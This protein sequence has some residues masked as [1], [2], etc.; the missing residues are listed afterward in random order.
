MESLL[1]RVSQPLQVG[2]TVDRFIENSW[3]AAV[4]VECHRRQVK[5]TCSPETSPRAADRYRVFYIVDGRCE[6]VN[7]NELRSIQAGHHRCLCCQS[8]QCS[9]FD[10]DLV[11]CYC[12]LWSSARQHHS[13]EDARLPLLAIGVVVLARVISFVRD[14]PVWVALMAQTS[15]R[16]RLAC[17]L[18][19]LLPPLPLPTSHIATDSTAA[20]QTWDS[21]DSIEHYTQPPPSTHTRPRLSNEAAKAAKAVLAG[22]LTFA[23]FGLDTHPEIHPERI[24]NN[25]VLGLEHWGLRS[26]GASNSGRGTNSGRGGNNGKGATSGRGANSTGEGANSSSGGTSSG[27]DLTPQQ[28]WNSVIDSLPPARA[29]LVLC[30]CRYYDEMELRARILREPRREQV[31]NVV[32]R[33]VL[34]VWVPLSCA[35]AWMVLMPL[36]DLFIGMYDAL[37]FRN[38]DLE[39]P[40]TAQCLCYSCTKSEFLHQQLVNCHSGSLLRH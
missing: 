36:V 10:S 17:A 38:D 33:Q 26:G 19:S 27:P 9:C 31:A 13:T 14:W 2:D 22:K 12:G 35:A 32:S 34:I 1:S 37:V 16:M 25:S 20:V 39:D 28:C 15:R 23:R 7:G 29:G 6:L 8:Q 11:C 30:T 40:Q 5:F 21:H 24:L 4:T 3:T 18:H